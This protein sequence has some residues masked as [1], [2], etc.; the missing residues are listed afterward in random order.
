MAQDEDD[1]VL[2]A[3]DEDDQVMAQDED[4]GQ[5][6]EDL[7]PSEGRIIDEQSPDEDE[8]QALQV[9]KATIQSTSTAARFKRVFMSEGALQ[10][11]NKI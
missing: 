3:Q 8:R 11:C 6:M 4:E 9:L 1:Q 2:M 7:E 10:R 5:T